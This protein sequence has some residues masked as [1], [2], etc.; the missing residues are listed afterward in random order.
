MT[1]NHEEVGSSPTGPKSI[2]ITKNTEHN[3][4]FVRN[5]GAPL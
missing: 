5:G 3:S 4:Y 2:R 1:F